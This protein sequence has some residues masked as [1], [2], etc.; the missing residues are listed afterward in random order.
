MA[1]QPPSAGPLHEPPSDIGQSRNDLLD[2]GLRELGMLSC[3]GRAVKCAEQSSPSRSNRFSS[4]M[5]KNSFEEGIENADD[6]AVIERVTPEEEERR[7]WANI[8]GAN[9][10]GGLGAPL[11]LSGEAPE[12]QNKIRRPQIGYQS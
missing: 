11:P 6:V 10:F 7:Y 9:P 3:V 5:A 2:D 8:S 1:A 4:A 12:K